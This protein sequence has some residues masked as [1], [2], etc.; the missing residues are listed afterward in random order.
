MR[1]TWTELTWTTG[2]WPELTWNDLN[3]LDL[4]KLTWTELNWK[5][6]AFSGQKTGVFGAFLG[7]FGAFWGVFGRFGAFFERFWAFMRVPKIRPLFFDLNWTDLSALTGRYKFFWPEL[8]WTESILLHWFQF[9]SEF[10]V[11]SYEN[12][13]CR[14]DPGFLFKIV[15]LRHAQLRKPKNEALIYSLLLYIEVRYSRCFTL[16]HATIR[17]QLNEASHY[18]NTPIEACHYS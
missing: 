4:K 16:R 18:S 13:T 10:Q 11:S 14:R 5:K 2:T 9:S 12:L 7:R 6:R 8:N 17:L 1:V 3:W 15:L